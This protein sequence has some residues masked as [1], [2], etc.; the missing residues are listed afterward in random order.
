MNKFW[1]ITIALI[2]LSLTGC[3]AIPAPHTRQVIPEVNGLI[4]LNNQPVVGAEIRL[5]KQKKLNQCSESKYMSLSDEKGRFY[6]KG[7]RDFRFLIVVGDPVTS[8]GM[9]IRYQN[10]DY[11]GWTFKRIGYAPKEISVNCELTAE[12]N[13][14]G[15]GVGICEVNK[16][17]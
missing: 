14:I 15:F 16:H 9:C 17:D 5:Y 4:T 7:N 2:V 8:W 11:K 13:E 10:Q 12:A 3:M 1:K 6:F